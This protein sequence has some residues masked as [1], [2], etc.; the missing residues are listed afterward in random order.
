MKRDERKIA[1]RCAVYARVSTDSGLEQTRRAD[2]ANSARKRPCR[3]FS[4]RWPHAKPGARPSLGHA[5]P[6]SRIWRMS[7][8]GSSEA[9]ML[10]WLRR[11][12]DAHRLAQADAEALVR[13]HGG[14]A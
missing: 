11:R 1:L 12:Q 9:R 3:T 10:R 5:A 7:R 13:D 2:R 6:S 4:W 14:E 8:S